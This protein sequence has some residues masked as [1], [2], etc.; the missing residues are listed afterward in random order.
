[1][2]LKL[3]IILDNKIVFTL[4]KLIKYD[5]YYLLSLFEN[6]NVKPPIETRDT[7]EIILSVL[8]NT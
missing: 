1:M 2:L 5:T 6:I 8:I 3:P 7:G 4:F